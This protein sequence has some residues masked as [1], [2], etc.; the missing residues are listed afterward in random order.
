[1]EFTNL[2]RIKLNS[3][4]LKK[5]VEV[6]AYKKDDNYVLSFTH[7][8]ELYN[9]W[10]RELKLSDSYSYDTEIAPDGRLLCGVVNFKITDSNGISSMYM[11]EVNTNNLNSEIAKAFPLKT[12][13]NRAMSSAIINYFGLGNYYTNEEIAV[14]LNSAPSNNTHSASKVSSIEFPYIKS[15]AKTNNQ[16]ENEVKNSEKNITTEEKITPEPTDTPAPATT[17]TTIKSAPECPIME[18]EVVNPTVD[19][20]NVTEEAEEIDEFDIPD[21][22]PTNDD[23]IIDAETVPVEA[24]E[25]NVTEKDESGF[26]HDSIVGFTIPFKEKTVEYFINSYFDEDSDDHIAATRL[27]DAYKNGLSVPDE[28]TKKMLAY[29]CKEITK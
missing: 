15:E 26:T 19:I 18:E 27:I 17:D 8:R 7:L 29:L 2:E 22:A 20:P 24:P 25:I 16:A 21:G 1:M 14:D 13:L 12:A 5:D 3:T 9:V 11:G 28:K 23:T 4:L 6:L 10:K